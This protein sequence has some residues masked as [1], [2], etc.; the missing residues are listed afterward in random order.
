MTK[1]RFREFF[2]CVCLIIFIKFR[3]KDFDIA[4]Q[5][6]LM[7]QEAECLKIADEVLSKL[8]LGD[9]EIRVFLL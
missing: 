6:E 1:G 3:F 8:E 5:G 9:F 2:Q 4:G 7:M